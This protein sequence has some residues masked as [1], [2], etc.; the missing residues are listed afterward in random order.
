MQESES[1]TLSRERRERTRWF[2]EA[3]F[4][5]FIH[6]GLYSIAA[7]GAIVQSAERISKSGYHI[8][9]EEFNPIRYNPR[10]WAKA[11]REAGQRY[12]VITTKNHEGFC[13]FDSKLTEFKST[14]TPARRKRSISFSR[15]A[16]RPMSRLMAA[17]SYG[18]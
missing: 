10:A 12:A 15:V 11:A 7:R 1:S 14:N 6:F 3:R 9:F 8:Y 4:G 16:Y 2:M 18:A 5:M 17:G 13:L